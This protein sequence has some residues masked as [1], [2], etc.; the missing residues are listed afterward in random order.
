MK[1][2]QHKYGVRSEYIKAG[3][4]VG[5]VFFLLGTFFLCIG[6]WSLSGV[7]GSD[8]SVFFG[9]LIYFFIFSLLT[10]FFCVFTY[11]LYSDIEV[12]EHGLLINFFRKQLQ[13]YW[14]DILEVKPV[15]SKIWASFVGTLIEDRYLVVTS[16]QL[17]L[18]HRLYGIVF[19]RTIAPSFLITSL[20][21]KSPELMEKIFS[22][23]NVQTTV[24]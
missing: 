5:F 23:S 16:S 22:K 24:R 8:Y 6:F 14:T 19:G 1:T 17:S 7:E 4:R 9:S 3:S 11:Y 15:K 20:I 2:E 12:N 21:G 18:F 10:P 13:V